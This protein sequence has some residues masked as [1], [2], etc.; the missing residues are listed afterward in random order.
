MIPHGALR[1][2]PLLD[3]LDVVGTSLRSAANRPDAETT[4]EEAEI[5]R[6]CLEGVRDA[7]ADMTGNPGLSARH[8][9]VPPSC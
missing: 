5:A 6:I 7:L 1:Q 9:S 8:R 2:P 4:L 3:A